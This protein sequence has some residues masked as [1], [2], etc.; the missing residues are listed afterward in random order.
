MLNDGIE[1]GVNLVMAKLSSP[2]IDANGIWEGMSGS[3]VY[4][5]ST[6]QIIGAVA[7]TLAWGETQVAGITPWSY[8][9]VSWM[10]GS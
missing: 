5:E 9:S 3:P 4:D 1:P 7:Y 10:K 6:G 8:I 2:E